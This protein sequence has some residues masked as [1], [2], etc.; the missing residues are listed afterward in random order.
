MRVVNVLESPLPVSRYADPAIASGRL[1]TSVVAVVTDVVRNGCPVVGLGYGSVGRYAQSG[2]I[3][4][5]FAPRLLLAQDGAFADASGTNLNPFCAW[6]AMM[7]GEKPGG[8]GERCV[9]VGA[10]DMAIWDAAAKIAGEPLY[11]HIAR[12]TGRVVPHDARVKVYAGGGYPYPEHDLARLADEMHACVDLGFSRVKIKIG[13]A[14]LDV[15][16]RRIEAAIAQ[17]PSGA[18]LAVDA[19]NTYTSGNAAAAARMLSGF[20]LWWFEDICDPLDFATQTEVAGIYA[21]PIAVGEALFSLP[22]ARLLN[23]YGGVRKD[24]DVL[25][26]DPVHCYGLSGFVQIV[27]YFEAE[28][29]PAHAFWPHGGHLF[30]LHVVAALGLGGAELNPFAFHPFS[31]NIDGARIDGGVANMPQAPGIGFEQNTDVMHTF[32]RVFPQLRGWEGSAVA[33]RFSTTQTASRCA[34]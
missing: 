22:E 25:V 13:A 32:H 11:R 21:G 19:M 17:L 9:A 23:R 5:R 30:S 20:D 1:D 26:F 31:A 8:H 7:A 27:D 4:E 24:R 16:R 28:G 33:Q 18:R 3:R 29:W 2:L 14:D 10:L 15:D 12:H 34:I 6:R